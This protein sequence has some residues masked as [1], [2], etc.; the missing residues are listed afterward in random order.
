MNEIEPEVV[1]GLPVLVEEPFGAIEERRAPGAAEVV[2]TQR[3]VA[4]LAVSGF[5]AGAATMALAH[6]RKTAKALR[7]RKQ[8]RLPFGDVLASNS[9]LVDVHLLRRD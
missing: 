9:F 8:K 3:Q 4:A 6:R 2:V 1:D 7:G 5:A